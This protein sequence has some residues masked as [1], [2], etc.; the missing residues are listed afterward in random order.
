MPPTSKAATIIGFGVFCVDPEVGALWLRTGSRVVHGIKT[1]A[2]FKEAMDAIL[3]DPAFP[4]RIGRYQIIAEY[5]FFCRNGEECRE[6]RSHKPVPL[7]SID[8]SIVQSKARV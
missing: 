2:T 7:E 3:L 4:W 1:Y 5:A 8:W 6:C